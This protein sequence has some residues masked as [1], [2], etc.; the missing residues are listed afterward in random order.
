MVRVRGGAGWHEAHT[1]QDGFSKSSQPPN[2]SA[3]R[4]L[5]FSPC[6]HLC[7]C[8]A[9]ASARTPNPDFIVC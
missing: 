9:R 6:P 7:F 3:P 2:I 5:C 8:E 1:L 4:G